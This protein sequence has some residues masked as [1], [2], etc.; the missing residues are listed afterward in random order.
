MNNRKIEINPKREKK[1]A[2]SLTSVPQN[3][4]LHEG[5][6]YLS[7]CSNSSFLF[8]FPKFA[9]K[10]HE[11]KKNQHGGGN[12]S[13][14]E[15]RTRLPEVRREAPVPIPVTWP[16][17]SLYLLRMN[18][19][20]CTL[21]KRSVGQQS[22]KNSCGA[23]R[24]TA[25]MGYCKDCKDGSS[26]ISAEQRKNKSLF[27]RQHILKALTVIYCSTRKLYYRITIK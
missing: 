14:A 27:C 6:K 17:W 22:K 15:A 3:N 10:G 12:G 20:N 18:R 1:R 23:G 8:L 24:D 19:V 4:F 16:T 2:S 5:G 13:E 11:I 21:E 26:Y 25:E 7:F 9:R